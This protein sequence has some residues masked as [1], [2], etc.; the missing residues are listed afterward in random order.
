MVN[1]EGQ[2]S[3]EKTSK[4][5]VRVIAPIEGPEKKAQMAPMSFSATPSRMCAFHRTI[6]AIYI[7]A[8][9]SK[10]LCMSCAVSYGHLYLCPQCYP[11][12]QPAR[13]EQERREQPKPPMESIL[14]LFGGLMILVGFF[15]PWAT[16]G[17]VSPRYEDRYEPV[18]SGFTIVGDYPEVTVVFIMGFL[19]IV[20][21]LLLIVL[22]TSP[23]M[24]K[25][26]PIGIRLLP[27]FLGFVAYVVLAEVVL[28]AETLMENIHIG[29]FACL[30]GASIVLFGGAI[31]IWNHY[32][33]SYD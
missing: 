21:E 15:M 7:C 16:S 29:W 14:G 22:I 28:R 19:I 2:G 13:I 11:P 30:F 32:K 18:I 3:Q 8:K 17:Y 27:M 26:P 10:P 5:N 12:P 25:N 33:G 24:A 23:M 1:E 6:P 31:K 4:P 20:V 9:C